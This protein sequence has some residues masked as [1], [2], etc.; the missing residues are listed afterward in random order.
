VR[1]VV[2]TCS[3]AGHETS[4]HWLV[5]VC[6]VVVTCSV[7]D[8]ETSDHWLVWV[9]IPLVYVWNDYHPLEIVVLIQPNN[10]LKGTENTPFIHQFLI[11]ESSMDIIGIYLSSI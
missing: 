1:G 7:A 2:V 8:H 6:G 5:W 10:A 4:D 3:V 11:M 9:H